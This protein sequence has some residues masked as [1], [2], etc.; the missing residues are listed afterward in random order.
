MRKSLVSLLS[1]LS[2]AWVAGCSTEPPTDA[3]REALVTNAQATMKT[4][5]ARDP[6]LRN[7]LDNSYAYIV[8]PDVSK[9]GFGVGG[10]WGRGIVYEQ[11]RFVGYA[12]VEE[13]AVGILIGGQTFSEVIVFKTQD[14]F[15]DFQ[16]NRLSFGADANVVALKAGAAASAEFRHGM[17]VLISDQGGLMADASIKGQN[18]AFVPEEQSEI[19]NWKQNQR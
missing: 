12:A 16:S 2:L 19:D 1:I 9:G 17:L 11:G 7:V 14:A 4:L 3:R 15:K 8:F 6:G 10:A 5:E 18:I 13:G